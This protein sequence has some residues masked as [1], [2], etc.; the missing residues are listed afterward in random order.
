MK[1]IEFHFTFLWKNK[2]IK[3]E[4]EKNNKTNNI[5]MTLML[6]ICNLT[7][8]SFSLETMIFSRVNGTQEK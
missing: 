1:L 6:V 4:R 3:T 5:W 7:S 2:I 8:L